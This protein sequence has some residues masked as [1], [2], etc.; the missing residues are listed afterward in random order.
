M[1]ELRIA[2]IEMGHWHGPMYIEALKNLGVHIA[3]I[4]DRNEEVTS[5]WGAKLSCAA[6]NSY[7]ELL[8]REKVDFVFAFGRHCDM[9]D[10]A[11]ELVSRNMPFSM[12][13]PMAL[14]WKELKK[15]AEEVNAKKLFVSVSFVRRLDEITQALLSLRSEGRLGHI[16]HYHSRFIGG[17][18]S[19]YINAGCPWMLRKAE[20]GGGCMMNFG[21]HAFD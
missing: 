15:V 18:T 16:T 8:E 21:T 14:H 10:I 11:K 1:G 19:R 5:K 9:L 7:I 6:Y 2:L 17:P 20:A 12:E 4:S 3:A 13:K